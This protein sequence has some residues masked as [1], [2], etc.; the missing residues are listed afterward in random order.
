[1]V[2]SIEVNSR[3]ARLV[4]DGRFI[5]YHIGE[6]TAHDDPDARTNMIVVNVASRLVGDYEFRRE[7]SETCV[8][9]YTE[10]TITLLPCYLRT[11]ARSD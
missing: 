1:M 5:I 4:V 11:V 6:L 7:H 10:Q 3:R 2:A 9:V 8:A